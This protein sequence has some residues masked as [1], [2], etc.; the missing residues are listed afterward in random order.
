MPH[1]TGRVPKYSKH[2]ASGQ[3]VVTLDGR[4]FYLGPY[5]TAASKREYDRRIAEWIAAGQRLPSDPNQTTVAEVA[6]AFRAH[7]KTYY[8][9]VDST[10]ASKPSM[11]RCGRC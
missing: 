9:D 1:L 6:A 2:R 7:A 5:G 10:G 3:A 4:D 11:R 8:C